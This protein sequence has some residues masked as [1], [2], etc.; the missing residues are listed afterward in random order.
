VSVTRVGTYEIADK[1]I[2]AD[3]KSPTLVSL[4]TQA[5]GTGT[6]VLP[7]RETNLIHAQVGFSF[8]VEYAL[9]NRSNEG[10]RAIVH[11]PA[12][13]LLDKRNGKRILSTE[14]PPST[15]GTRMTAIYNLEHE[16][17]LIPGDWRVELWDGKKRLFSNVF[18]LAQ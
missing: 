4:K 12:P 6:R 14:F 13:G 15:F 3:A 10:L 2:V 9:V 11:I 5:E 17:E 16:S 7:I 1:T 8:G 18:T